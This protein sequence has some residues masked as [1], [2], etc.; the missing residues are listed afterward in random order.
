M[1][2]HIMKKQLLIFGA[3]AAV[4]LFACRNQ[5]N[6]VSPLAAN[7]TLAAGSQNEDSANWTTVRWIDSTV[8]KGTI[9]EG[10]KLEILFHFQNTGTKP[11]V[12]KEARPSCGCTVAEK[13]QE[14]VAPGK[15]GFIRAEFDSQNKPGPNHKTIMVRTNTRQENYVLSF[16]VVVNKKS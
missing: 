12:I 9:N 15:E 13:P 7:G 16:S 5:E 3:I 14:P 4:L 10:E 2:G 8:D 1:N 6:K 11:L